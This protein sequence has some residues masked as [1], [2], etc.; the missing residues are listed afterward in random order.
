[1]Y[2]PYTWVHTNTDKYEITGNIYIG[3]CS[4]LSSIELMDFAYLFLGPSVR[5]VA[6]PKLPGETLHVTDHGILELE[7]RVP[8]Q[9][10]VSEHPELAIRAV[11]DAWLVRRLLGGQLL[12]A[13]WNARYTGYYIRLGGMTGWSWRDTS[14]I[15]ECQ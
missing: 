8:A 5:Y 13:A 15:R 9:R 7:A 12:L 14:Q 3:A 10:P 6:L 11:H 4:I 2:T 1:M